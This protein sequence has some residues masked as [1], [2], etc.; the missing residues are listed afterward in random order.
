MT[1]QEAIDDTLRM[2][3]PYLEQESLNDAQ[4][5]RIGR[6]LF[7]NLKQVKRDRAAL[8]EKMTIRP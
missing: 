6:H 2:I 1:K 7:A 3:D 5:A 4:A 8:E